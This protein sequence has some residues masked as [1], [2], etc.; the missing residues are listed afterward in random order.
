MDIARLRFW[1]SLVVDEDRPRPLPN[2]DY[3]IVVGNSLVSKLD[4]EVLTLDWT[5]GELDSEKKVRDL[6]LQLGDKQKKFFDES[7]DKKACQ[8][9]IRDLKIDLLLAQIELDERR[10]LQKMPDIPL[11]GQSAADQKKTVVL[12]ERL[13]GLKAATQKLG[14]LRADAAKTLQYFDWR[15]DFPEV[16]NPH[17]TDQPGFD[18][19][20][21]NPP[22][23]VYEGDKKGEIEVLNSMPMYGKTK[24]GKLNAY[25]LFLALSQTL[26]KEHTGIM[27]EIF[28]NSFLADSSAKTL[29]KFFL[30]EQRIL[31]IDSFPERD[32]VQKRV[33]ESAK[34]SVCILFSQNTTPNA[35]SFDLNIWHHRNRNEGEK[36]RLSPEIVFN[37]DAESATIPAVTEAELLL[38]KKVTHKDNV[39]FQS[40]AYCYQGEINLTVHKHLLYPTASNNSPM[41]KGAAVQKWHIREKMSQG[42]IEYLDSKSYLDSNKGGK[43]KHHSERRIVMQGI[44]GVDE[45]YR[46]K[47]TVLESGIF[48]GH[49]VNYIRITEPKTSINYVL[50]V[51]NSRLLNWFFKTT[52]TNSNVNGYEV[53]NLPFVANSSLRKP[54][55]NL[56][57]KILAAKAASATVDTTALEAEIDVLV[58][59]LYGL[60]YEEVLLVEPGF[61]MSE[62]TYV[63]AGKAAAGAN[64][65][66]VA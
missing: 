23:D 15:L 14:H 5:L 50:G 45:K 22:Y 44:T 65:S 46:L 16:L 2:L 26:T 39:K 31:Q 25:K 29:R 51:L 1:L 40:I 4:S 38:L 19:V 27:C 37:L 21:G 59:H 7:G 36:L 48:C 9:E 6:T 41:I 55:E 32:N 58:Y 24:G 54:I 60:K 13:R 33:F 61:G 52:S 35:H 34:M 3:K 64:N 10:V 20:I 17:V 18:I 28:Q 47:S 42:E 56:V 57:T 11:F 66:A 63:A 43:S 53:N 30:T 8:R 12:Q 62:G 49:S